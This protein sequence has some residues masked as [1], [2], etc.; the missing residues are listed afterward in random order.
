MDLNN[1]T[2]LMNFFRQKCK[3]HN[4]KIT[5]QRIIIYDEL[6][7]SKDHP[8]ADTLFKKARKTLP[9]ISF[10]TVNRT[11]LTFARIGVVNVVEGNGDPKR[12]DP[13]TC[14]HH[15]LR[16][17]KCNKIIDFQSSYYDNLKIPDEIKD[18]FTVLKKRVCIEGIC[19]ECWGE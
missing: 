19:S 10:D 9:N 13:D 16:C 1:T 7:K 15:H 6:S 17:I 4:L 18:R 11:V 2:D 8:S 14:S 5:P 12:F 3:E